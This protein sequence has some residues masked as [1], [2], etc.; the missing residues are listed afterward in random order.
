MQFRVDE[1]SVLVGRAKCMSQCAG[2]ATDIVVKHNAS[3][4]CA[5]KSGRCDRVVAGEN[6]DV[7]MVA[8]LLGQ[9][10][11]ELKAG[12]ICKMFGDE[13]K[14]WMGVLAEVTGD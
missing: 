13:D 6:E 5:F 9:G 1:L 12:S 8:V 7:S 3:Q 14:C 4:F 10:L 2:G 11:D